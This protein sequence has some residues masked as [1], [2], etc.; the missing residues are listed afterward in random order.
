MQCR[1]KRKTYTH[2]TPNPMG[3]LG[4]HS[5]CFDYFSFFFT[6]VGNPWL[7]HSS[8]PQENEGGPKKNEKKKKK[9]K[10]KKT[11]PFTPPP[12]LEP[13]ILPHSCWPHPAGPLPLLA[14]LAFFLFALRIP[15]VRSNDLSVS[16]PWKFCLPSRTIC[17]ARFRRFIK[18]RNCSTVRADSANQLK[19]R[20]VVGRTDRRTHML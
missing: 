7:R 16:S 2:T 14:P 13:P 3:R 11:P 17:P 6:S 4:M 18:I 15:S 20:I 19:R 12:M 9:K 5:K 10:K 8:H 1:K